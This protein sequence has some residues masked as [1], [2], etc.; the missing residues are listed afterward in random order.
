MR[1]NCNKCVNAAASVDSLVET[2]PSSCEEQQVW[3]TD[4]SQHGGDANH[5]RYDPDIDVFDSLPLWNGIKMN[6]KMKRNSLDMWTGAACQWGV[7]STNT[8]S[9]EPTNSGAVNLPSWGERLEELQG[10]ESHTRRQQQGEFKTDQSA[11]NAG[12]FVGQWGTSG[13]QV[14]LQPF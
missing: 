9:L 7:N 6:R 10:D 5:V 14:D 12:C 13:E 8:F 1:F 11:Q 3:R 2:P 4:L